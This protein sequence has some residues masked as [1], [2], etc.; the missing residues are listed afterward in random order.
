MVGEGR[1]GEKSRPQWIVLK[2]DGV[3]QPG[4]GSTDL[5]KKT[6]K[7]NVA[8]GER[9]WGGDPAASNTQ[10]TQ[11]EPRLWNPDYKKLW[12]ITSGVGSPGPSDSMQ[13][14]N[15]KFLTSALA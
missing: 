1:E 8:S 10:G 4:R 3:C 13:S 5:D 14:W 6:K 12:D 11:H 2:L 9:A 7:N 15:I